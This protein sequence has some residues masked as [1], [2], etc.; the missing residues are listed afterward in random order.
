MRLFTPC[1]LLSSVLRP[2][3]TQIEDKQCLKDDHLIEDVIAGL[4]DDARLAAPDTEQ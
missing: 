1:C 3:G 4:A 2:E